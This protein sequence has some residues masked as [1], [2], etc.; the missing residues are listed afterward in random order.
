MMYTA[1]TILLGL[2]CALGVFDGLYFHLYKY[3]LHLY[4]SARREHLIHTLRAFV[5][6]PMSFLLFVLNTGGLLLYLAIA[7]VVLDL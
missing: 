1:A 6:V 5:F 2:F 4:P 7:L 3:K